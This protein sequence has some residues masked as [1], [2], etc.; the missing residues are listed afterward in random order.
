MSSD[1]SPSVLSLIPV[2][3]FLASSCPWQA[4]VLAATSLMLDTWA[5]LT[6]A[7][8]KAV[9]DLFSELLHDPKVP[10]SPFNV[11]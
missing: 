2:S 9:K 1:P 5:S 8:R 6:A 7:E 4:A 3:S 10:P 11:P